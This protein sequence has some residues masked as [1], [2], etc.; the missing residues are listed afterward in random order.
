M[1]DLPRDTVMGASVMSPLRPDEV[2][3]VE[4]NADRGV[5]WRSHG[6]MA[7]LGGGVAA[8]VLVAIGNPTPWV[9]PLAAVLAMGARGW[10]L[11]SEALSA[12]WHLTD[13]RLLGPAGRD[14]PLAQIRLA[15]GFLGDVQ[16][17]TQAG[18]KHL[19]KY[20][21]DQAGVVAAIMSAQQG[22][23]T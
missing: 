20:M 2:M 14:I 17:I 10:Y 15:R 1:P 7:L 13:Q 11:A 5:Y 19:M 9:G 4:W 6:I 8:V 12:Q 23:A 18:D 22:R 16:I 21:S 3:L